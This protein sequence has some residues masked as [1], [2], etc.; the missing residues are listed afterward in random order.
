MI[1]PTLD[2]NH[3][4]A[5]R[6]GRATRRAVPRKGRVVTGQVNRG[7]N[8]MREWNMA[9]IA[10]G[11]VGAV[12]SASLAAPANAQ[13]MSDRSVTTIMTYAWNYT[14]D[15]FTPPTGK[16]VFIDKKNREKM[17]VPIE[18][19]REIIKVARLTA[20]A[21]ICDLTEDQVRN[22]RSLMLREDASKKWTPQQMVYINQLHLTTVMMLV[23]KLQ[24]VEQKDGKKVVVK[25]GQAPPKSCTDEQK[26]K[27]K[28]LITAYVAS[29]P[30]L[31]S[32]KEPVQE[33]KK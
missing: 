6:V 31:P 28:E 10:G 8:K 25:E 26:K 18:K 30:K 2:R 33:A 29:G 11:I 9:G 24:I 14:P 19:G 27:I 22:Y 32:G 7:L 23:G 13:E 12:L 1:M 5:N 16:T 17:T 15:K 4:A 3:A 20:H 21:Q